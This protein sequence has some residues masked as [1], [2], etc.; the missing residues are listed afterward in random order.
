LL[1]VGREQFLLKKW[2]FLQP[3]I[4]RKYQMQ[5]TLEISSVVKLPFTA[6]NISLPVH[7]SESGRQNMN[8]PS[9]ETVSDRYKGLS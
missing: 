5:F 8:S 7:L 1:V 3:V 2:H 9:F 6:L 4:K